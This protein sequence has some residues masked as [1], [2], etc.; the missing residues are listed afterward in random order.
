[1]NRVFPFALAGLLFCLIVTLII[2]RLNRP[3]A[4]NESGNGNAPTRQANG[5]PGSH[6]STPGTGQGNQGTTV[7][8]DSN[9]DSRLKSLSAGQAERAAERS[10]REQRLR[11]NSDA[12]YDPARYYTANDTAYNKKVQQHFVIASW[13]HSEKKDDPAFREFMVLL[14]ENGFGIDEYHTAIRVIGNAQEEIEVM[15]QAY[16]DL[17]AANELDEMFQNSGALKRLGTRKQAAVMTLAQM[18]IAEPNLQEALWNVELGLI[19]PGDGTIGQGEF[20]TVWGDPLLTE[21]DWLD[22]EFRA[23][24][25][26]YQGPPRNEQ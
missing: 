1:M 8:P 3:D 24:R 7:S 20:S 19:Q 11:Q 6:S 22:S 9:I 23:A 4:G 25:A 26:R 14:L 2:F 13:V 12:Y 17:F 15:K 10:R 21:D 16:G 5:D 18:G